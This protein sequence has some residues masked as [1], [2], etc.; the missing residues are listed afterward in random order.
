MTARG[1]RRAGRWLWRGT[2]L[3]IFAASAYVLSLVATAPAR[4]VERFVALPAPVEALGGTVWNGSARLAGAHRVEWR[5]DPRAS[6]P[7]LA[8]RF[9]VSASG[10]RTRLSGVASL[11]PGGVEMRAVTGR[12]GWP[13]ARV[14]APDLAVDCTPLVTVDLQRV[15]VSREGIGAAGTI[16]TGEGECIPPSGAAIPV[17]ALRADLSMTDAAS[18]AVLTRA[19]GGEP[20]AEAEVE[21]ATWLRATVYPAGARLVPGLPSAAPTMLEMELPPIMR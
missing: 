8:L 18:R 15:R 3:V 13:L 6:L 4:V 1:E 19:E 20:L 17:P 9:D 7:A 21:G 14:F 5:F 10:P 16:R 11:A 2:L 12:A